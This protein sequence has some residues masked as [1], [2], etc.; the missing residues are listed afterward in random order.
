MSYIERPALSE[1]LSRLNEAQRAAVE[2]TEGP[3]MVIAGPG[4]GKTQI[5]AARIAYILSNPD[6]GDIRPEQVLCLTYTEAGTMAMRERLL[7]FLGTDAYRV[8]VYTFHAFCNKIIQ[9]YPERFGRRDLVPIADLEKVLLMRELIDE[10]DPQS[11]LR[12]WGLD[13]YFDLKNL[14]EL[15]AAFKK[16]GWS[17]E[18]V[19]QAVKAYLDDLPNREEYR[20]KRKY[21][22]F[23]AGDLK[24]HEIEKETGA[25]DR[26]LAATALLQVYQ[27]RMLARGRYDYEDMVL[28][29]R[30]AFDR[31]P[32]LLLDQQEQYQYFLV[33]EYQDTN[34]T[35]NAILKQLSSY[36]PN[37]NVFVVGDDDQSIFRFQ[38]ASLANLVEFAD[39]YR[40][41]GLSLVVLEQ[42]YRS[43]QVILDAAAGLISRN[44]ERMVTLMQQGGTDTQKHLYA[45]HPEYA[46]LDVRPEVYAWHND[47]H[48]TV[49]VALAIERLLERGE[50]AEEIAVLYRNHKQGDALLEYLQSRK[51]AVFT[52]KRENLFHSPLSRNLLLLLRY[53]YKESTSPGSADD[54]L[55]DILHFG[56]T[57]ISAA[58]IA[59]LSW[60]IREYN[61]KRGNNILWRD[62]LR[63]QYTPATRDL[64]SSGQNDGA[65][66]LAIYSRKLEHWL[67][68][69]RD[70]TLQHLFESV[71]VEGQVLAWILQ[72]AQRD[73]LLEEVTTL[74]DFLKEETVRNPTLSL[75]EFILLLDAMQEANIPLP[76]NRIIG[77]SQGVNFMT[78]H[79]SKGLE[80]DHVFL[81]G[82]DDKVWN[83]KERKRGFHLPDT[84]LR[85][86]IGDEEEESRRLFYV[87][88]TRARK[89]LQVHYG[90]SDNTGKEKFRSLFVSE[91]LESGSA[92]LH[93]AALEGD[94]FA[95]YWSAF[96]NPPPVPAMHRSAEE[97]T[98]M[99]KALES[100]ELSLTT[101][102]RYLRCPRAFYYEV[103]L[104]I[105]TAKSR[106]MAFGIAV[107]VA[108]EFYFRGMLGDPE[109]R[110]PDEQKMLASF[111][112]S[113]RN[114]RDCF[115]ESEFRQDMERGKRALVLFI[116]YH[117][118]AWAK[119]KKIEVERNLR[120]VVFRGVP[121]RG[122]VDRME[123]DGN[124]IR[125]VDYKTGK[126]NK[127]KFQ[128]PQPGAEEGA[129][130]EDRLGGDYW[131]QAV[132]YK[133]L[134]EH[135]PH[136]LGRQADES[137]FEFVEP[138]PD[139]T[140]FKREPVYV[141]DEDVEIV[142]AQIEASWRGIQALDFDRGCGEENCR[143]CAFEASRY[144]RLQAEAE[145]M[146]AE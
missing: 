36:W 76:M 79:G 54:L 131:R 1:A 122:K 125:V 138:L 16:E 38:G 115:T 69:L 5:L 44:K 135:D 61:N 53:L 14:L 67:D 29:V 66:S 43:S 78:A 72:H 28:W 99:R 118:E 70:L 2:Q 37:P 4:T 92:T 75:G 124:S 112:K 127:K 110:W 109:K 35:Q 116:E 98:A 104:R 84:L 87:A 34:G 27:Q 21:R 111:E 130:H 144:K 50:K 146:E 126:H 51:I 100:F 134:V 3:V 106:F 47:A 59:R 32:D 140:S 142:G 52:K 9:D 22:E 48:E 141:R 129:S 80:F 30:E 55:F 13:P 11:P 123:H 41:N 121:L 132:F 90:E 20:Y 24:I 26:L 93:E 42:N 63:E 128:P 137:V 58:T 46:E 133:I 77:T 15:G 119:S 102:N 31:Y 33:D 8:G 103:V 23:N 88:L 39:Q 73:T 113:L 68:T 91:L 57:G 108:L 117:R 145:P 143:W 71:L 83:K 40:N 101:L 74:F 64:F 18:E 19:Q 120:G 65:D 25:M 96:V 86:N 136:H 60:S 12:R 49:G 82:A 81:V 62:Y 6:L 56:F 139:G 105:P 7:Q 45:A 94:D 10:L 95:Q 107:H 89:S 97:E 17:V 85:S 114:H